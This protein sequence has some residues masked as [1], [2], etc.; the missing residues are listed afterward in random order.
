VKSEAGG[1]RIDGK[2]LA[3]AADEMRVPGQPAGPAPAGKI[4]SAEHK[5]WHDKP[6]APPAT[7]HLGTVNRPSKPV[8][9]PG[10]AP[11]GTVWSPEHGH[12]HKAGATL[13]TKPQ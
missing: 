3:A 12:W 2:A 13:A 8:P 6:A 1:I 5:H 9:Q 4:W 7:V 11:A 10:P